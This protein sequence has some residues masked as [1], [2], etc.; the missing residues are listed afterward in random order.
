MGGAVQVLKWQIQNMNK[1]GNESVI[2]KIFHTQTIG[3]LP[4]LQLGWDEEALKN[5]FWLTPKVRSRVTT[6]TL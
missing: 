5:E 4:I 6:V 3:I 1:L 2:E